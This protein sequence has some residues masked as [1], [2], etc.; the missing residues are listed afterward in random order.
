MGQKRGV[1]P[2]AGPTT[3]KAKVIKLRFVLIGAGGVGGWILRG[4]APT[5]NYS[6]NLQDQDRVIL[7]V[8][9]DSFEE[10]NLER[11]DFRSMGKKSTSRTE[12]MQSM[13]PNVRFEDVPRWVVPDTAESRSSTVK[14]SHL[15][16]DGDVV[17][18]VVDNYPTRAI[19]AD[20]VSKL[21]NVDLILAGN[22]EAFFGS[23]Y[24]Y[25][26]RDGEDVTM[27]PLYRQ[28]LSDP[29]GKNPGEMSCE[30]RARIDGGTQL[31]WT[32]MGVAALVGVKVQQV[33]LDGI[34]VPNTDEAQVDFDTLN[35]YGSDRTKTTEADVLATVS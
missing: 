27:N 12:E 25:Q 24:H 1:S 26:R 11:Q 35:A 10:H 14:A 7:V 23:Y 17:I 21:E 2:L 28:E 30:E 16:E 4:L 8:D 9:G 15:I 22:D 19:V 31:I 13:Y 20:A 18:C 29:V 33:I 34:R 6:K 32:N 3:L 5:V